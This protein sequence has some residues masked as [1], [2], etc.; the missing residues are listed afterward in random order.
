VYDVVAIGEL[1]I[2]FTPSMTDKNGILL[3]ARNPG[4]APANVLAMNSRLGGNT[5]FIGKVGQDEFGR[6]LKK[7]LEDCGVDTKGLILATEANTT[8][9]F[10][11]LNKAG[12][13]SFSFYRNNSADIMLR[14][15]DINTQLIANCNI[16]H[17]G[18]VSLTD[19]PS[20]SATL[21][22]VRLAKEQG[23]IISF[24]PNY[25][26]LLWESEEHARMQIIIALGLADI[27]KVSDDEMSFLTGH[28]NLME[29]AKSISDLGAALVLITSGSEGAFYFTNK[30]HGTVPAYK[31]RTIDTT[32]AG[33]AFFGS[34]L[35]RLY[36]KNIYEIGNMNQEELDDI[37]LFANAAGSL[38]TT[39]IGAIHSMPALKEIKECQK[40]Y[41]FHRNINWTCTPFIQSLLSKNRLY[42]GRVMPLLNINTDSKT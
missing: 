19:E 6:Y 32:G 11:H 27:V 10:V 21:S 23:K 41:D 15:T 34:V 28:R 42:S 2:D 4:G 1:L 30:H 25:R 18:S 9:A 13:R 24:D 22:A 36:N 16:F 38:A 33:D 39:R 8:L 17:F 3:F 29:G 35:Y 20:R 7:T 31:V 14:I 26:E 40:H 12:D 5:A 37:V